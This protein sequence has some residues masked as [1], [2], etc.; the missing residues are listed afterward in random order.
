MRKKEEPADYSNFNRF[1]LLLGIKKYEFGTVI[2]MVPFSFPP[3]QIFLG[4]E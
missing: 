1:N 4:I 2:S 3:L